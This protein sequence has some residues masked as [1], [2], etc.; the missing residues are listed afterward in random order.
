MESLTERIVELET[1]LAYAQKEIERLKSKNAQDLM[2]G[3]LAISRLQE[4]VRTFQK[5]Q[6]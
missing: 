3:A 1:E 4:K 2:A 5:S 6:K